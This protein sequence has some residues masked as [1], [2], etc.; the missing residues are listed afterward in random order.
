MPSI[1]ERFRAARC[2]EN[3]PCWALLAEPGAV[4]MDRARWPAHLCPAM[5]YQST[6]LWAGRDHRP[7]HWVADRW[8][9]VV[10]AEAARVLDWPGVDSDEVPD[11]DPMWDVTGADVAEHVPF[12]GEEQAALAL[13]LEVDGGTL[14]LFGLCNPDSSTPGMEDYGLGDLVFIVQGNSRA[15]KPAQHLVQLA[16]KWWAKRR[17]VV[18]PARRTGGRRR[19]SGRIDHVSLDSLRQAYI[20]LREEHRDWRKWG[21]DD[22]RRPFGP[23]IKA[24]F[25]ARFDVNPST[26]ERRL[27]D[28]GLTWSAFVDSCE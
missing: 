21:S 13:R 17:G 24:D 15:L 3:P 20:E 9:L 11:D 27:D 19:G 10:G 26:V 18:V 8:P 2:R 4:L 25:A 22:N 23:P 5:L 6:S 12:K 16:D 7:W 28:E 14:D 1:L